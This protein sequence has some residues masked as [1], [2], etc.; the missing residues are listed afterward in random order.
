MFTQEQAISSEP[1][2]E[3][4][5]NGLPHSGVPQAYELGSDAHLASL[6]AEFERMFHCG[7]AEAM[8]LARI[9]AENLIESA[10][11]MATRTSPLTPIGV[12]APNSYN[13]GFTSSL[14]AAEASAAVSV[15]SSPH[16][17]NG[18]GASNEPPD[19]TTSPVSHSMRKR[20]TWPL[21][22][23]AA[24]AVGVPAVGG[25]LYY[26]EKAIHGGAAN[27]GS[28]GAASYIVPA[29]AEAAD[30]PLY[31]NIKDSE[32]PTPL[33][34]VSVQGFRFVFGVDMTSKASLATPEYKKS[35]FK[36]PAGRFTVQ[37]GEIV[38]IQGEVEKV[39]LNGYLFQ[40]EIPCYPVAGDNFVSLIL[41]RDAQDATVK[42]DSL[43]F[44]AMLDITIPQVNPGDPIRAYAEKRVERV[45]GGDGKVK[46]F[47]SVDQVGEVTMGELNDLVGIMD[48]I[49]VE[50]PSAEYSTA[51]ALERPAVAYDPSR[52]RALTFEIPD[53][54]T[55]YINPE[56]YISQYYNATERRLRIPLN[57]IDK[58]KYPDLWKIAVVGQMGFGMKPHT[59]GAKEALIALDNAAGEVYSYAMP[60]K[61]EHVPANEASENFYKDQLLNLFSIG[62]LREELANIDFIE[63]LHPANGRKDFAEFIFTGA[64]LGALFAPQA[65]IDK[66]SD[67]S[68]VD[69][70]DI[71]KRVYQAVFDAVEQNTFLPTEDLNNLFK[72]TAAVDTPFTSFAEVKHAILSA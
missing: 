29:E 18:I 10:R 50:D 59:T 60:A 28:K 72:A 61:D 71:A 63:A 58:Q 27:D 69:R 16:E 12:S 55:A 65:V 14:E 38:D 48:K 64:L 1:S 52:G 3:G 20:L 49:T 44:P 40:L 22:V 2:V 30:K 41:V 15:S 24:L 43:Q 56:F 17:E 6:V 47:R 35:T 39:F 4:M 32:I 67:Q 36:L 23:V 5:S 53:S 21:R 33:G 26:G 13:G 57:F 42:S 19:K 11:Y 62:T 66:M 70:K 46:E 8:G 37:N 9:R 7:P 34:R 31:N 51:Y 54:R 25:I 45:M 68:W